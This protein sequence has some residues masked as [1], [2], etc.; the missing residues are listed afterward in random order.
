MDV[1]MAT[2]NTS[3]AIACRASR[4]LRSTIAGDV[5]V[6]GDDGYDEARRAFF[7]TADQQPSVVVLAES[8]TDVVAAVQFAR[9]HGMRIAP[10]STGHGALALEPLEDAM[11]LK[12]S[13]MRRVDVDPASRIARAEAGAEWQHV[14]VAAAEH[15]L[16][17]LAGTSP[18][19]GVTGYT[20]GGGIGWLSRRYGLAANSVTAVELLTVDGRLARVDADH[21]PDLFWALR[22]GGGSFGVVTALEMALFPVRKLYAGVL[23]FPIERSSEVLY[24]WRDWTETVPD[25]VTSIARILRVP[26]RPEIPEPLR[27]RGFALVEAAYIGDALTGGELLGPLREL[28]AEMDTFAT[29]PAPA[30]QML[31]MDPAEP[32]AGEADGT[33]LCDFGACAIDAVMPLVG[34]N[35]NTSLASFEVRH[36]GG[37]LAHNAPGFGAQ[38][39][40]NAEF[41]TVAGGMTATPEQRDAV[42]A[43]ARAVKDALK[44]WRAEYDYYN[45]EEAPAEAKTLLPRDAYRRLQ[46]IKARYDRDQAL[47]SAHP[48]RPAGN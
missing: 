15:G 42:R 34:P 27:G 44:A 22:G 14:T 8:S 10:Q 35:T 37:A 23:F 45:F 28:G 1:S 46:E 24:T 40:I 31:H 18:N 19:V 48:V 26:E 7:L 21:E 32:V 41:V 11:L 36:L 38:A 39:Q 43:D 9:A 33:L 13:R 6:P 3:N 12:T 20:L 30:L 2:S 5:F 29:I 17:A 25:E 4:M 47:V 16:A